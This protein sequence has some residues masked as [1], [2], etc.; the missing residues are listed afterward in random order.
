MAWQQNIPTITILVLAIAGIGSLQAGAHKL[1]TGGPRPIGRDRFDF[2][3]DQRDD[4]LKAEGKLEAVSC[5]CLWQAGPPGR[6]SV[7]PFRRPV[8]SP[9]SACCALRWQRLKHDHFAVSG[10]VSASLSRCSLAAW[11]GGLRA[12]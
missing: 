2:L 3:L 5:G 10:G 4:R 12:A 7:Q 11:R 6:R 9:R 8:L 1:F